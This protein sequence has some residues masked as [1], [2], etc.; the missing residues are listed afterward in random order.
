MEEVEVLIQ[1]GSAFSPDAILSLQSRALDRSN[2]LLECKK[3]ENVSHSV[4]LLL[5]LCEKVMASSQLIWHGLRARIPQNEP[6][7]QDTANGKPV[8]GI[9]SEGPRILFG[10]YEISS[11]HERTQVTLALQSCSFQRMLDLIGR[12]EG[13]ATSKCWQTQLMMATNLR[14]RLREN[15]LSQS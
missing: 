6:K 11:L 3:C 2:T 8:V 12:I 7:Q 5:F 4:M 10:T 15:S 9:N 14:N 1:Q 13:L